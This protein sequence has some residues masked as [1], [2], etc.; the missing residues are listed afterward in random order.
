MRLLPILIIG[1]LLIVRSA[2]WAQDP[3]LEGK[4]DEETMNEAVL[5]EEGT[6][7]LLL[8]N[9]RSK[10]GRD[11]YD[12]F[13]R[14]YAELPK[15]AGALIPIDSIR[16][17]EPTVELDLNAFIVTIEELPAFGVGTTVIVVSLNDQIIWQNYVQ[18]RPEIIEAYA[19]EAA[20]LINQY[21]VNYQDV[22]RSLES[23]DQRGTGVF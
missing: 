15:A 22:Q 8:D 3:D 16:T 17:P 21:V 11:F 13:F 23:E 14:H 20:E 1:L 18:A 9:S 4:L 2:G 7:T 19:F 10:I 12:L 6:Q 5:S